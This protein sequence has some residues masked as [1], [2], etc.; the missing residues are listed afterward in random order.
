MDSSL[1]EKKF[2]ALRQDFAI[3]SGDQ[4]LHY[5]DSA[6]SSQAPTSV[7]NAI[8]DC[9][10]HHYSPVHR[11]LY[12]S[13][14]LASENYENS[15]QT[16]AHFINASSANTIV[17]TRSATEAINLVAMGWA[18]QHLQAGDEVCVSQMEHHSNFLPWQR[19]CAER[20]ATLVTIPFNEDMVIS[21]ENVAQAITRKTR[22]IAITQVSNVLGV[23]NPIK[24]IIAHAKSLDIPVL[25][26]AAQS[27]GHLPV[28]V[29]ELDCD[30]LVASAH[31]MCGPT[32][33][34]LSLIHI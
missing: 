28:D 27:I 34:G 7:I 33:I 5:L 19:V 14:E 23:I 26:D 18:G 13:A 24:E 15:R 12:P 32:G 29:Q 16:L 6:A 31:K 20:G 2:W 30:F 1:L 25:V 9:Y 22:L 3:F 4:P 21:L 10:R 17:F 8:A 11:G